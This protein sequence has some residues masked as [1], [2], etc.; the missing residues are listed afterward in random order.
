[1]SNL[2]PSLIELNKGLDMQ[3]PKITA[4]AGTVLDSL[5]YEQVDFQGQKR[6]DGFTRYDGNTLPIFD[7]Y[8]A[9][10][11]DPLPVVNELDLV[12]V[13]D[14]V[15]AVVVSPN[16]FDAIIVA[17]INDKLLTKASSSVRFLNRTNGVKSEEYVPI[18]V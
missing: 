15:F 3:T 18:E 6:I 2:V 14:E 16:S 1:M 9:L 17:V 8:Y 10:Y 12:F 5:N 13:D 4:E 11:I 7:E